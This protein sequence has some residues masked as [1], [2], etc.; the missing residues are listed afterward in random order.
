VPVAARLEAA[1]AL[2]DAVMHNLRS[3]IAGLRPGMLSNLFNVEEPDSVE[4]Q[5]SAAEQRPPLAVA[6]PSKRARHAVED[7][8]NAIGEANQAILAGVDVDRV[9]RQLAHSARALADAESAV[10]STVLPGDPDTLVLRALVLR[11]HD[12]P[13]T[14]RLHPD[15]LFAL[16]DTLLAYPV[17]TGLPLVVKD[18]Q[19]T[20]DPSLQRVRQLGIGAAVAVPLAVRGQ[21]FGGLA[22]CRSAGRPPF[23]PVDIRLVKTFAA[24][25]S[26]ALEYSRARDE[27][28]RL[29]VVTERE[30]IAHEL[31]AGVI[32]TLFG[33]GMDLQALAV[34]LDD[35][36]AQRQ[37]TN[38]VEA[39]DSVIR[40]LRN[41]V[42]G[43]RPGILADRLVDRA[44]RELAADFAQRTGVLPVV[45]IDPHLAA[46]LAG[47]T[48]TDVVQIAREALSNV[49]RH[50]HA[51]A[52]RLA[53][54]HANGCAVLEIADDGRGLAERTDP[55]SGQGLSNMR[56]R[57]AALGGVVTLDTGLHRRGTT[58]RATVP[59]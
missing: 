4:S 33:A 1:V 11:E 23:Q 51:T 39:I 32:Q 50:A 28:N 13:R 36:V 49:A 35:S 40:D 20:S 15:D 6:P 41:Y 55:T 42:F 24:Q 19:H 18:V 57:A 17:R 31:H 2:I 5:P 7:R 53:L 30:R 44:L 10:I 26:I 22:V 38:A 16:D 43:I 9:F 34:S 29:A 47:A 27:L 58:V 59:L 12:V 52:C 56:A 37:L 3:V 14:D 45:E 8:L 21:V 48:A 46:R 54:W 25:A